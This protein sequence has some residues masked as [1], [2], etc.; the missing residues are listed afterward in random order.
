MYVIFTAKYDHKWPSRAVTAY[1]AGY[2]GN[3]KRE[4]AEG[5]IAA[6]AAHAGTADDPG[7]ELEPTL[8]GNLPASL[9]EPDALTPN[10]GVVG[11]E[12]TE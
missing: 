3:V 6:K 9:S 8:P 1:R 4:V 10:R 7:P 5:A 2:R 11:D 12:E